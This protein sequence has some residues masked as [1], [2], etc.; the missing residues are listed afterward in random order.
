A[1]VLVVVAIGAILGRRAGFWA[2]LLTTA[3]VALAFQPLRRWVVRV[4]D[5][6]AFGT[7]AEPY[8][9][10]AEFTRRLG[11]SPDP[12]SLLPAVA[13]AATTAVGARRTTVSLSLPFAADR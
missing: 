5:R 1:Y 9:A 6:L 2:S 12:A 11:E 4:A 8:D 10:L 3:L 13:D 7:A